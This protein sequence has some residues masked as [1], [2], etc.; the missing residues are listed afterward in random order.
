MYFWT[1]SRS[2]YAG[3]VFWLWQKLEISIMLKPAASSFEYRLK[4]GW[5]VSLDPLNTSFRFDHV[6]KAVLGSTVKA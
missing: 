1:A 2:C 6:I 5:P 4:T 3:S